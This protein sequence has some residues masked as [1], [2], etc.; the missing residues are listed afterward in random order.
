VALLG[1]HLFEKLFGAGAGSCGV[2][3]AGQGSPC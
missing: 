1:L 2:R 3:H